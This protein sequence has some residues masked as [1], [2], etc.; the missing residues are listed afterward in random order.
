MGAARSARAR[1]QPT[2]LLHE[3]PPMAGLKSPTK[4]RDAARPTVLIVFLIFFVLV[5]IGLGVWGYYGYAGQEKLETA[6]KSANNEKKTQTNL[7]NQSTYMNSETR[8]AI[9]GAVKPKDVALTADELE[10]FANE[11]TKLLQDAD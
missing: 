3:V 4:K 5:S 7:A 8:I 11:R 2:S 1:F 10:I 9:G 6:A